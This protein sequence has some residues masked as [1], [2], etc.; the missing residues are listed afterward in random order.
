MIYCFHCEKEIDLG[1]E[2]FNIRY[3]YNDSSGCFYFHK[4]CIPSMSLDD[5]ELWNGQ[6]GHKLSGNIE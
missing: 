2:W 6:L 3:E 1:K 5:F 4:E